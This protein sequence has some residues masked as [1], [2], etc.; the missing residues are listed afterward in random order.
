MKMAKLSFFYSAM[1]GGKT[2]VLLQ[3]LHNYEEQQKRVVLIK[4]F[5]CQSSDFISSKLGGK[6]QADLVLEEK[7]TLYSKMN[8]SLVQNA[9]VLLV[10]EAHFL[11][12]KQIEELWELSKLSNITVICYGLKTNFKSML[13]DGSKRLF[14][15]ADEISELPVLPMCSCGKKACFNARYVKDGYTIVGKEKVLEGENDTIHYVPLCGS[16]YLKEVLKH[17]IY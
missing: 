6:R 9:D 13:F 8:Q 3:V 14:E 4:P 15:L 11:T 2:T 16:C 1:S 12:S 10:D 17:Q 5:E 7:D